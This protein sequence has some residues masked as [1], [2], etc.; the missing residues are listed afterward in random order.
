VSTI[1]AA[2]EVVFPGTVR[3]EVDTTYVKCKRSVFN[4]RQMVAKGPARRI[5]VIGV[6]IL[7][8]G[9]AP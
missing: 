3:L 7:P 6:T 4:G 5:K 2:R 1:H 9:S 8:G